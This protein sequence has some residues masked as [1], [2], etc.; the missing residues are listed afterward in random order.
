MN[1]KMTI[2][3]GQ[4]LVETVVA[5]SILVLVMVSTVALI[6]ISKGIGNYSI[7][8]MVA[9]E[10]VQDGIE[11]VR[12]IRDTNIKTSHDFV[13]AGNLLNCN[14]DTCGI[15]SSGQTF[16]M[17]AS[18]QDTLD[19][20]FTRTTIITPDNAANPQVLTVSVRV[21]WGNR[22]VQAVEELTNWKQ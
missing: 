5:I 3:K 1:L 12:N 11:K 21:S 4:A 13:A 9:D 15:N 17:V 7:E 14:S 22:Q 8:K 6:S 19:G 16:E 20:G 2:K 10:Y 18:S